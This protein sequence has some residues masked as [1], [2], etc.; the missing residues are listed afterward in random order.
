L[1]WA[2]GVRLRNFFAKDVIRTVPPMEPIPETVE[3]VDGL[4]PSVDDFDILEHL[5]E[6][7]NRAQ[8]IV[9]DLVGVSIGRIAKGLTFTLVATAAEIAV[10]DGIQYIA[11]GPCVDGAHS[12]EVR[13][14][15]RDDVLDEEGWRL[16]AE[17]TAAPAV[18]STLTLPVLTEDRV[19]GTVNLYAASERAFVGHHDA[20]AEVFGAWAAGAVANADLSFTTRKQAQAA[21]QRVQQEHFIDVA[22]GI[23]A[24]QLGVDVDTAWVR[25]HDAAV[26]AGVTLAQLARNIVDARERQTRDGT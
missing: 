12:K 15:N 8:E 21:P 20:L 22:T 25:L 3:A 14:F 5:T 4:D 6:L 10:L 7:G 17:A 23:V 26:R 18:H 9:P 1:A 13:E 19:V 16:F 11:G 2:C 24:A